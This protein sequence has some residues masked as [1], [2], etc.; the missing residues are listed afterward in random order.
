MVHAGG[1]VGV[2]FHIIPWVYIEE[3]ELTS[4]G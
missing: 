3:N 2:V 4:L 1:N